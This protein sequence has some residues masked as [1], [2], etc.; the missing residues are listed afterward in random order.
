MRVIL[1]KESNKDKGKS[2]LITETFMKANINMIRWMEK[3]HTYLKM[4]DFIRE[5]LFKEKC[6][7]KELENL[8]MES[9]MKEILLIIKWMDKE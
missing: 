5:S 7:E 1:I 4:M 8:P 6:K 2:I 9:F 3:V